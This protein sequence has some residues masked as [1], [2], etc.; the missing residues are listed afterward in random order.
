[1]TLREYIDYRWN[2]IPDDCKRI[3]NLPADQEG[4]MW[5]RM[6]WTIQYHQELI[7]EAQRNQEEFAPSL[8]SP[9]AECSTISYPGWEQA[10]FRSVEVY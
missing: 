7:E 10:M 6:L 2:R 5:W 8:N 1:M 4:M 9:M 3:L